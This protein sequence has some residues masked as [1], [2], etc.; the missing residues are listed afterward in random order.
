MATCDFRMRAHQNFNDE[1]LLTTNPFK[2]WEQSF[3]LE[4]A[5]IKKQLQSL[6]EHIE[7]HKLKVRLDCDR[8]KAEIDQE[9]DRSIHKSRLRFDRILQRNQKYA[10]KVEILDVWGKCDDAGIENNK[11]ISIDNDHQDLGFPGDTLID[12]LHSS[13][14]SIYTDKDVIEN[15]GNEVVSNEIINYNSNNMI[16]HNATSISPITFKL[17]NQ[18]ITH[19]ENCFDNTYYNNV[20]YDEFIEKLYEDDTNNTNENDSSN[21]VCNSLVIE[22]ITKNKFNESNDN[23]KNNNNSIIIYNKLR[24]A[25]SIQVEFDNDK[26]LINQIENN[27]NK[28]EDD[29]DTLSFSYNNIQY[30]SYNNIQDDSKNGGKNIISNKTTNGYFSNVHF[31]PSRGNSKDSKFYNHIKQSSNK[32]LFRYN[33]KN[34]MCNKSKKKQRKRK[35]W[36][37]KCDRQSN[38]LHIN[39]YLPSINEEKDIEYA[40]CQ[41][42]NVAKMDKHN[43]MENGTLCSNK[44]K[45]CGNQLE[46]QQQDNNKINNI[47]PFDNIA[48]VPKYDINDNSNNSGNCNILHDIEEL[49]RNTDYKSA[50]NSIHAFVVFFVLFANCFGISNGDNDV[51]FEYETSGVVDKNNY[52]NY[53]INH[54]DQ[55]CCDLQWILQQYHFENAAD[56]QG[57]ELCWESTDS[58]CV[59]QEMRD[60]IRVNQTENNSVS[61]FDEIVQGEHTLKNC[62]D[63]MQLQQPDIFAKWTKMP[64]HFPFSNVDTR[65]MIEK[66]K[67]LRLLRHGSRLFCIFIINTHIFGNYS[68][69]NDV[70]FDKTMNMN[71]IEYGMSLIL[72]I[73]NDIEIIVLMLNTVIMNVKLNIN[74]NNNMFDIKINIS[75]LLGF[76]VALYSQINHDIY[77]NHSKFN[78]KN[79]SIIDSESGK[80]CNVPNNVVFV[81]NACVFS[82]DTQLECLLLLKDTDDNFIYLSLQDGEILLDINDQIYLCSTPS[83]TLNLIPVLLPNAMSK[84]TLSLTFKY[85]GNGT[86]YSK[87]L[88]SISCSMSDNE[89]T[90]MFDAIENIYDSDTMNVI[91]FLDHLDGSVDVK[92]IQSCNNV[93][94]MV[95]VLD[96]SLSNSIDSVIYDDYLVYNE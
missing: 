63:K 90:F 85:R 88:V 19:S 1:V 84:F 42:V 75:G 16:Q 8:L 13:S 30:E 96:G 71:N 65:A 47:L 86:R 22:D 40:S 81:F 31:N 83:L 89:C 26:H 7:S 27:T 49:K 52:D 34:N 6:G 44:V 67:Q 28:L 61:N 76:N 56:Y 68:L 82:L 33:M 10:N 80:I 17:H 20:F 93:S 25:S 45:T 62:Q 72:T 69:I 50:F 4:F 91:L 39:G 74:Y 60:S 64:L 70:N 48:Q 5:M 58:V 78:G 24:S 9:M 29:V 92:R 79:N 77:G 53:N 3:E 12:E 41:N 11:S 32:E 66:M 36:K 23:N 35:R 51:S 46:Y 2:E 94:E 14:V 18:N 54:V 38:Q 21:L 73:I 95:N 57:S 15:G 59:T 55:M 37:Y 43:N 87:F